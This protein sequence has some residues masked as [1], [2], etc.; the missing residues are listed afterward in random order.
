MGKGWEANPTST[1][2]ALPEDGSGDCLTGLRS[3]SIYGSEVWVA[4][5]SVKSLVTLNLD[6]SSIPVLDAWGEGLCRLGDGFI[7]RP[8]RRSDDHPADQQL[9]RA[10][11]GEVS[12]DLD[13]G[14]D[15]NGSRQGLKV[16]ILVAAQG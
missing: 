16:V 11:S 1:L 9:V 12:T 13:R 15:P 2:E 3:R 10:F 7:C 8:L 4:D 6:R 14:L 5:R